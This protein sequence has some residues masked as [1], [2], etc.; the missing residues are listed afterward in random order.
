MDI[1]LADYLKLL[2][3]SEE[4]PDEG[5]GPLIAGWARKCIKDEPKNDG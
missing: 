3:I 5:Q 4:A 1:S 2:K